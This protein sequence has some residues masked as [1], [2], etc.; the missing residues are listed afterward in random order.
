MKKKLTAFI[1]VICLAAALMP[2]SRAAIVPYFVAV[3]E[4]LLPFNEDTMPL[5]HGGVYFVPARVFRDAGVWSVP[6][7]QEERIY[8][9][10]GGRHVNFYTAQGQGVTIDQDG[11]VRNWPSARRIG[12]RFYLPL[13][14]VSNF[15]GLTYEIVEVGYDVI[16]HPEPISMLR[17]TSRASI[18]A[19]TFISMNRDNMRNSY[20]S[21]FGITPPPTP[22]PPDGT[23]LPPTQP[24]FSDVTI[25]LSF[26][27]L[28]AGGAEAILDA[29]DL[30]YRSSFFVSADDIIKNP[31]LIRRISGSGHKLGIWLTE[32]TYEEYLH[33][34]ALLFEAAKVK[35]VIVSAGDAAEQAARMADEN[36]LIYW[37]ASQDFG[38][39]GGVTASDVTDAMPT[40]HGTRHNFRFACSEDIA[41]ILPGLLSFLRVNDYTVVRITETI[42]PIR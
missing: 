13:H 35:T 8:L 14:H 11:V 9:Y 27:D 4:T 5:L 39:G 12:N 21:F 19:P 20:N 2:H 7:V 1:I 38:R 37:D 41:L 31:G 36:G 23:E 30:G 24:S 33:A 32:G 15:F 6:S 26:Y 16:P 3:N 10:R 34:S 29:L 25:F 17:I 28:S 42:A 18:N 22:R 40:E